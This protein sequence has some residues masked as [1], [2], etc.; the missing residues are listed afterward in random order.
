M[1]EKKNI[2][3]VI[4]LVLV[5]LIFAVGGYF[6][7]DY[8]LN[9]TTEEV[10]EEK[11]TEI[12]IDSTKDYVYYEN[13]E[14][15]IHEIYKEDAILNFKGLE[16]INAE[17]HNELISLSNSKVTTSGIELPEGT[18]CNEDLYSFNYREY[19][20]N[21]YG[22]YVSLVVKDYSYNCLNGSIPSNIKS[23]IVNKDT[24]LIITDEELLSEFNI[25][26]DII[27]NQVEKRLNTLQVIDDDE[28]LV[29]NISGTIADLKASSYGT[30][31]A[32]SV[33][34][35]GYLMLNYIVKS[36]KINYNDSIEIVVE[37]E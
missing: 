30:N 33:S 25:T 28:E 20:D 16:S 9:H 21:T 34:K 6:L 23:Y 7:M 37:G 17:L 15:I 3:G 31:K 19:S 27:Y 29:I 12:R 26:E 4:I 11:K 8:M 32:L 35:N 18:I 5:I 14:E 36:N 1:D 10:K 2:A 13:T 24:G 22:K